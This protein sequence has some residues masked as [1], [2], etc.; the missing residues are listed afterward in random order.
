MHAW[1]LSDDN[2]VGKSF[3]LQAA[4]WGLI[5]GIQYGT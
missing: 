4:K 5:P 3:A 1:D 2:T